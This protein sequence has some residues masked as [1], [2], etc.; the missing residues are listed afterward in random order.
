[1]KLKFVFSVPQSV[2]KSLG[3][4]KRVIIIGKGNTMF[5]GNYFM[6]TN[7]SVVQ[8]TASSAMQPH[9]DYC[10]LFLLEATILSWSSWQQVHTKDRQDLLYTLSL[11]INAPMNDKPIRFEFIHTVNMPHKVRTLMSICECIMHAYNII[12]PCSHI[13]YGVSNLSFVSETHSDT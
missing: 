5:I 10:L 8:H 2:L 11:P 9:V 12:I 6:Y 7:P 3:A 1:M 4:P 13:L